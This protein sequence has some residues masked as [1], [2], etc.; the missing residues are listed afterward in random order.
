MTDLIRPLN[1]RQ[2]WIKLQWVPG[3]YVRVVDVRWPGD[4]A[5]PRVIPA[6]PHESAHWCARIDQW[7]VGP[8][9]KVYYYAQGRAIDD[10]PIWQGVATGQG[11]VCSS[12][13][14][15]DLVPN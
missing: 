14:S 2:N 15:W 7:S 12:I 13:P 1:I 8:I 5:S 4:T 10:V 9:A 3:I 6:F 11:K